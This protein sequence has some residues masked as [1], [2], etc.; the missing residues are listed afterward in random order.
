MQLQHKHAINMH[1]DAE[2]SFMYTQTG[3]QEAGVRF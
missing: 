3:E 1:G 2:G